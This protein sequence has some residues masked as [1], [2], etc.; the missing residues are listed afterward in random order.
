MI[1][2][3]SKPHGT[4]NARS[5][6]TR[7]SDDASPARPASAPSAAPGALE[8][9]PVRGREAVRVE[10]IGFRVSLARRQAALRRTQSARCDH[11][12]E[13]VDVR[14][15]R[16]DPAERHHS[17]DASREQ[18][19]TREGVR[20]PAGR[21]HDG[22]PLQAQRVGDPLRRRR[23]PRRR[24][25]RDLGSSRHSSAGRRTRAGS[26][27]PRR[28]RRA[29]GAA[30]RSAVTRGATRASGR[31]PV[32]RHRGR[33]RRDRRRVGCRVTGPYPI[34]PSRPG[35]ARA[36]APAPASLAAGVGGPWPPR[37][38]RPSRSAP[39]PRTARP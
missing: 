13:P 28:R 18:R 6:S 9:G 24:H 21:A 33:G 5:S 32:R 11:P 12:V 34:L 35:Q 3:G 2:A 39:V 20:S 25:G 38:P 7:P 10:R 16:R 22:E 17:L 31:P 23:P 29:A 1:D 15:V 30:R 4:T 27:A 37:G 36:A 26:R 8:G 14:R 19:R